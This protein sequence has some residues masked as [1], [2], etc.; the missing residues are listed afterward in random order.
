MPKTKT[1]LRRGYNHTD[2]MPSK[3]YLDERLQYHPH[4]GEFIWP[5]RP[6]WQFRNRRTAKTFNARH[7]GKPAGA[8]INKRGQK[9][10]SIDY[11]D[12]RAEQLAYIMH[13]GWCPSK[14]E[15][16]NG[17]PLD[18]RISN[19]MTTSPSSIKTDYLPKGF[20]LEQAGFA[21]VRG[22]FSPKAREKASPGR[23]NYVA[24]NQSMLEQVINSYPP[25]DFV[26]ECIDYN[27]E[28]GTF[29]WKPRPLSHFGNKRSMNVFNGRFAGQ[30]CG[31]P[32]K[33]R[34]LQ[35]G[36]N[37]ALYKAD[38]LAFTLMGKP[39]PLWVVHKDDGADNLRWDNLI[40]VYPE[41]LRENE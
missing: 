25:T 40:G 1:A 39:V 26:R 37:G 4:S 20:I 16:W 22:E 31:H 34:V 29:T 2:F 15:F 41:D 17:N 3:E 5:Y 33:N 11:F 7:A 6:A 30:S 9:I 14:V 18:L 21:P 24:K 38:L 35:I 12:Y 32:A 36:I 28:E 27:P 8:V 19:L 23:L 13:H 10:I